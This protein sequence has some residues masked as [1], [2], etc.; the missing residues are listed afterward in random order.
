MWIFGEG[1]SLVECEMWLYNGGRLGWW[2]PDAVGVAGV[3]KVVC[4]AEQLSPSSFSPSP[5][6]ILLSPS[7]SLLSATL[8]ESSMSTPGVVDSGTEDGALLDDDAG[9][10]PK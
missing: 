6:L 10:W 4:G 3:A 8:S 7:V 1:R 2:S 9:M 5:V